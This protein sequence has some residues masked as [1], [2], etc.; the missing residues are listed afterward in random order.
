MGGSA[1]W[2]VYFGEPDVKFFAKA[3]DG[4]AN[5]GVT[6]YFLVEI[7]WL[8]SIVLLK[9]N[10]GTREAFHEH[11]FN[12]LTIWLWGMVKE[13]HRDD[14][15]GVKMF[16]ATDFKITKRN[17]FHKIEA[18]EDTWAISFRGPWKDHWREDRAGE[19]V[20]LTHGR[21]VIG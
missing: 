12:A 21:K 17:V 1:Y 6:G 18:L 2:R 19:L 10:K 15:W 3:P 14:P 20:T 11:A 5:S 4:G 8:F 16:T 7:K 9:F 13:H